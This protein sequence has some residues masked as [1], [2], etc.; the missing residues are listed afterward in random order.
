MAHGAHF[1]P[2]SLLLKTAP[3]TTPFMYRLLNL[4]GNL[5]FC[6]THG[7]LEAAAIIL[8]AAVLLRRRRDSNDAL[9]YGCVVALGVLALHMTFATCGQLGR[10]E[11]YLVTM[12]V[13]VLAA[14]A[15]DIGFSGLV[16][17]G[18]LL[19]LAV[20]VPRA[21]FNSAYCAAAVKS[22][23]LQQFQTGRFLAQAYPD[24]AVAMNDIGAVNFLGHAP[25]LDL[26]GLASTDVANLILT[27]QFDPAAMVHLIHEHRIKVVA[28]YSRWLLAV[29][30]EWRYAGS[31][32]AE[33]PGPHFTVGGTTVAFYAVH[34]ED[35]AALQ[36]ALQGFAASLPKGSTITSVED[37]KYCVAPQAV[38]R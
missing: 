12:L 13:F 25:N 4:W 24:T 2:N 27:H 15:T 14:A 28:V 10:Y 35:R 29:P 21:W 18:L 26:V 7:L 17:G 20:L 19:G 32:S 38:E 3:T 5:K 22:I 1:F 30:A 34:A 11:A 9:F 31:I 23:Y 37:S 6:F 33:C 8:V 16:R 36:A